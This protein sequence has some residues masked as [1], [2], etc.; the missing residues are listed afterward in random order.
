MVAGPPAAPAGRLRGDV[1]LL[2]DTFT[3]FNEPEIGRAAVRVLEAFGTGCASPAS[4]AAAVR[5]SPRD[6]C[7]RRAATPSRTW[8]C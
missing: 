1:L 8:R 2:A 5:S 7:E 4:S 3:N 6:Y